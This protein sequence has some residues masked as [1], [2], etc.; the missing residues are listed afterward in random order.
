MTKSFCPEDIGPNGYT[1]SSYLSE[2]HIYIQ[3]SIRK[4]SQD[5]MR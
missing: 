1:T 2:I 5:T 4:P 3:I